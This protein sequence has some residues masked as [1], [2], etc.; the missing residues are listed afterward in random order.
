L[1]CSVFMLALAL[2]ATGAAPDAL[3]NLQAA[4][5]RCA[6]R[7]PASRKPKVVRNVGGLVRAIAEAKPGQTIL[8]ADGEYRLESMLEI[9]VPNVTL[10]GQSGLTDRVTLRGEGMTEGRVG[11][12][13]SIGTTDVTIADL[14][15]GWVGYH[16]I[17]VRGESGA[18]RFT[19]HNV[20][21]ADTGQQLLKGSTAGGPRFADDGLVACSTF[22]YTDAA[23]GDYTNGVDVLGGRGWTVRDSTFRRIRGPESRGYAA[24]PSI[25]FWANSQDITI[26]RNLIADS[27]RGIVLGL[28]P[29]ASGDIARDGQ[30]VYD[31]QRGRIRQ[32]VVWNLNSWADEAIEAN[33]TREIEIDHNTVLVEG[34]A[35]WSIGIRFLPA[36][37]V[38][39]NNLTNRRILFRDRGSA[40]LEGNVTDAVADW[41][42]DALGGNLHLRAGN[43]AVDSGVAVPGITEDFDRRPRV[44]GS[45]PDAGAFEFAVDQP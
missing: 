39:R 19:M 33:A 7:P 15:I 25:L 6:W 10:R 40:E 5:A 2:L 11:V 17:Q 21:V 27:F 31:A 9:N 3:S 12:A 43:P 14:T 34:H 13:V 32:N 4:C 44:W 23:P 22:E 35:D 24:G 8:L 42:A 38:V 29:H 28:G 41:F 37:A 30:R 36:S 1:R 16:G 20:R 45:A 18:S 26:E